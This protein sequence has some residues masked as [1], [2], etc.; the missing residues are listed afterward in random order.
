MSGSTCEAANVMR[1]TSAIRLGHVKVNWFVIC[2]KP[3]ETGW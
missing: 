1:A 3:S 2:L